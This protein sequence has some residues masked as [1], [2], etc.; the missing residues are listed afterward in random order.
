VVEG[1][2]AVVEGIAAAAAVVST[3]HMEVAQTNDLGTEPFPLCR[4]PLVNDDL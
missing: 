1:T 2:A 4:K 3:Y